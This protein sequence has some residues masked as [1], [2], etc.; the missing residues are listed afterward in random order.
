MSPAHEVLC[1][2]LNFVLNVPLDSNVGLRQG[3]YVRRLGRWVVE[4]QTNTHLLSREPDMRDVH[5]TPCLKLKDRA[6]FWK[7]LPIERLGGIS[8]LGE[9]MGGAHK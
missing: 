8:G 5:D 6:L 9:V 4:M 2:E 7:G 3:Q 1:P